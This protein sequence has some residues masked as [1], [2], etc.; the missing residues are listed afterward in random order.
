M[1]GI[2][3]HPTA[4]TSHRL[5]FLHGAGGYD[6]DRALA[7]GLAAALDVPLDLPRLPDDDMSVEAWARP[8]RRGL[9]S[10]GADGLVIA[11]S[12]GASILLRVLADDGPAVR[13]ATHL[14]MPDWSPDGWDAPD[15]AYTGFEP[16]TSLS[17]QHCRDDEVV[18]FAHLAL[19]GAR[20]PN[21]RVE[22]HPRGGHQ[23]EGL[24]DEIASGLRHLE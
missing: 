7:Q 23:F 21:A 20:L 5:L 1:A 4:V 13:R 17:L 24:V 6:D 15:Y 3:D 18:P 2:D 19:D 22:I 11:H 12:F 8:V 14:A 9:D 10:V 16:A